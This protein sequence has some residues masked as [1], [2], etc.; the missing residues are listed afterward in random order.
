MKK[1]PLRKCVATYEQLPKKELLRVV[2]SKEGVISIDLSGKAPGR[3]A[4]IKKS[5]EAVKIAKKSKALERALECSLTDEF[6]AQ[7]ETVVSK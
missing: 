2:K 6:Y 7:L 3:G 5:L 1:I 4:Y